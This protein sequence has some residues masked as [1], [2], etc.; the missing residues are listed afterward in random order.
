MEASDEGSRV[1]A[2]EQ[3]PVAMVV[4]SEDGRVV[5]ANREAGKLFDRSRSALQSLRASDLFA[6]DSP[7]GGTETRV[8]AVPSGICAADD[9]IEPATLDIEPLASGETL[10]C[11]HLESQSEQFETLVEQSTN[12]LTV[13]STEGRFTYNSPAIERLFGYPQ[14]GLVGDDPL[15]YIH[16]EDTARVAARI[17]T[18]LASPGRSPRTEFRFRHA[19][20]SWVWAET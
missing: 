2:F 13:L 19:D 6:D 18:A 5:E 17:Q 3:S 4:V 9:T 20:G 12:L 1:L 7:V 10:V 16:R 11:V 8:T 14:G 15:E